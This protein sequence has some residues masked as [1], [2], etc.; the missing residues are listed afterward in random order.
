MDYKQITGESSTFFV[1][2]V[3]SCYTLSTLHFIFFSIFM[4]HPSHESSSNKKGM[5]DHMN[6][7][8]IFIFGAIKG[9]FV[10]CIIGFF[11]F[12][13]RWRVSSAGKWGRGICGGS[14][15]RISH[16]H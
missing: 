10:L 12:L 1:T 8:Q 4:D 15:V 7:K 3:A 11:L 2:Y 13:E 16:S 5:F 14:K 9:F 6:P